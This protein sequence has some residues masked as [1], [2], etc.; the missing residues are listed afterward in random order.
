M[1]SKI[2]IISFVFLLLTLNF[3]CT[4]D[5]DESEKTKATIVL[6]NANNQ[7]VSGIVVYAYSQ[8]TWQVIGDVPLH[9]EGQ[10]SSDS[11]GNAVFNNIEYTNVFTDLNN[12]QN[13]F[14][15]S[16]HYSLNGVNKRKV[17]AITF[18]KGDNK[19]ETLILN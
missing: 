11:N 16:A 1:K 2:S 14:R 7:P 5:E 18:N 3:A 17:V 19:T 9:A 8:D 4:K 13:T 6:K 15:F 10:A 12:N